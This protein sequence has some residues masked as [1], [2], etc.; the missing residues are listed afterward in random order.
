MLHLAAALTFFTRLPIWRLVEIPKK[1]Y[2]KVVILW[3]LAGWLT[4]GCSAAVLWGTAMILPLPV[5][6]VC[7]LAVRLLLT[8]ALHEDGLADFFDG[9]GG[10]RDREQTLAIMKDSH[11]GSY[12]VIAL[13]VYF[14]LL[15]CTL[16]A[17]PV[18]VACAAWMCGDPLC[19]AIAA[20]LINLL[21]YARTAE[22][23]K[24]K[25]VYDR[26]RPGE[27]AL[28]LALGLLPAALLMPEARYW[29]AVGAPV[30]VFLLL[31]ALMHHRLQGYTGDCCGATFLLCE[32]S[33]YLSIT[34]IYYA[35]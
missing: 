32:A 7:A 4:G 16:S 17:L 26:M 12:G 2:Q 18:G 28:T 23:S 11:I 30:L 25:T 6:I 22:Q 27:I 24:S 15:G 20:Q 19:K 29:M 35:S 10:G 1:Y 9:F 13:I 3:P 8:G 5:A 33:F 34:A 21:P 31:T 14:L